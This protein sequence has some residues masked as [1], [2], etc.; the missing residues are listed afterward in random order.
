[1][2]D[3]VKKFGGELPLDA[4]CLFGGI[5]VA[6]LGANIFEHQY[7]DLVESLHLHFVV[8][9]LLMGLFFLV[10][11]IE[12][13]LD[14]LPGGLLNPV[15]KALLPLMG[16]LGGVI[17]PST[18]FAIGAVWIISET[19]KGSAIPTATDIAVS[20]VV[21]RTIFARHHPAEIFLKV[22]AIA[23]DIIGILII[24]IA[25]P[26]GSLESKAWL[27]LPAVTMVVVFGLH[28]WS[29]LRDWYWYLPFAAVSWIGFH[30]AHM[31]AALS[32]VPLAFVAPHP[33]TDV[34]RYDDFELIRHGQ[35]RD[36]LSQ[37]LDLSRYPIPVILFLFGLTNVGIVIN[38]EAFG[39][40]TWLVLISLVVGKPLGIVVFTWL[41]TAVLGVKLS[42]GMS[43][44]HV[45][46]VGQCAGIGLT[47]ALFVST[48]VY[49]TGSEQLAQASIGALLSFPVS[50]IIS[51]MA[52]IYW[53]LPFR[54]PHEE[55]AKQEVAAIAMH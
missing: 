1:M 53:K 46:V 17:M 7:H 43:F 6:L 4:K 41:G 30:E 40:V 31:H 9:D 39:A 14:T 22:L 34:D 8:N 23:D 26:E 13:R 35:G 33:F 45:F 44:K 10:V 12:I 27:V 28:R 20:V 25:F 11:A 50:G 36:A 16:T 51:R 37:I 49:P 32:L 48:V 18:V 47:V 38:G 52:A 2:K 24:A 42:D 54:I 29:S 3:V 5:L 15:R 55:T 21:M 19:V